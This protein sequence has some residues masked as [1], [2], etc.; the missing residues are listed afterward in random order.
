MCFEKKNAERF[1][2]WIKICIT[3]GN[4]TVMRNLLQCIAMLQRYL[5][6]SCS[7][8]SGSMGKNKAIETDIIYVQQGLEL[9]SFWLT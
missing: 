2:E 4:K 1:S 5:D 3:K 7:N 6:N 8:I 9:S